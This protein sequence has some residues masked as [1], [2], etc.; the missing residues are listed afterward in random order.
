[1][2]PNLRNSPLITSLNRP[3]FEDEGKTQQIY[4]SESLL[5]F[6][7]ANNEFDCGLII[8]SYYV[9]CKQPFLLG[10]IKRWTDAS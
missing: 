3:L 9:P 8:A 5:K 1:M 10:I 6:F 7:A 4:C 2:A